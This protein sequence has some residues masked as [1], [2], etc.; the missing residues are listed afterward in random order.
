[1]A[2]VAMS[3]TT[4]G[5]RKSSVLLPMSMVR[6]EVRRRRDACGLPCSSHL[7]PVA[8]ALVASHRAESRIRRTAALPTPACTMAVA[9]RLLPGR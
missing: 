2:A 9:A 5:R 7:T 1:V 8:M 4:H 3:G 6:A